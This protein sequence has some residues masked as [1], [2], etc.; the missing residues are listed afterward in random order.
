M[1]NRAVYADGGKRTD[2]RSISI[3]IDAFDDGFRYRNT[4]DNVPPVRGEYIRAAQRVRTATLRRGVILCGAGDAERH[5]C[6]D[7]ATGQSDPAD[8]FQECISHLFSPFVLSVSGISAKE[9]VAMHFECGPHCHCEASCSRLTRRYHVTV[10]TSL[11]RDGTDLVSPPFMTLLPH[12]FLNCWPLRSKVKLWPVVQSPLVL[13][14]Q[15]HPE[16]PAAT[17]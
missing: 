4:P 15:P 3:E 11:P 13:A 12:L 14:R 8:C 10:L 2:K 16:V 5:C 17:F 1:E 9:L 7:Q 6:G